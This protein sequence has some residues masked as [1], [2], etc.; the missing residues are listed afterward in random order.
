MHKDT[1]KLSLAHRNSRLRGFT[2]PELLIVLAILTLSVSSMGALTSWVESSRVDTTMLNLR[3]ALYTARAEAITRGGRVAICRRNSSVLQQCAGN[4]A[5]GK[6]DW[7]NGWLMFWDRD[8]DRVFDPNKG[9][10][11]LRVFP[12][13]H[14]SVKLHWNRGDYIAYQASGILHSGSGTFCFGLNDGSVSVKEV[15][16]FRT[17][18]ARVSAGEC[19]YNFAAL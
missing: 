16:I 2:L 15:V 14:P 9:D 10:L 18:R 1:C 5:S 8:Q 11:I 4:S 13:A 12:S 7:S 3:A 6:P 17:G 19:S